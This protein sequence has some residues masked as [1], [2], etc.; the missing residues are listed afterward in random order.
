MKV[1]KIPHDEWLAYP[2]ESWWT[3]S[4]SEI[5]FIERTANTWRDHKVKG[6]FKWLGTEFILDKT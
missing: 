1:I 5:K 2:L 4:V 3:D 6:I